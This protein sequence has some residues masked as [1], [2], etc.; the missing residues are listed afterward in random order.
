VRSREEGRDR[1]IFRLGET[2][3]ADLAARKESA[4]LAGNTTGIS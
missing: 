4:H 3:R 2:L 1:A